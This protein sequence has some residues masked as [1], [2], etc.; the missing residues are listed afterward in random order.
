MLANRSTDTRARE[1]ITMTSSASLVE[2]PLGLFSLG[3]SSSGFLGGFCTRL[4]SAAELVTAT[5]LAQALLADGEGE[6]AMVEVGLAA[7]ETT[8][9][10]PI[11]DSH[12]HQGGR[13][14]HQGGQQMLRAGDQ[15]FGLELRLGLQEAILLATVDNKRNGHQLREDGIGAGLTVAKVARAEGQDRHH[16]RALRFHHQGRQVLVSEVRAGDDAVL[17]IVITCVRGTNCAI[18]V[19]LA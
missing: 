1:N 5:F 12:R 16:R 3:W 18:L 7:A 6:E 19:W 10:L 14:I 8:H 9:H 4:A 11:P 15:A 13:H 2:V 17:K